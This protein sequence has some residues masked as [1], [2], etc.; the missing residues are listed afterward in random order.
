MLRFENKNSVK[1]LKYKLIT[2]DEDCK[3]IYNEY[4]CKILTNAK[5]K[6]DNNTTWDNCKKLSN[7]YELIHI[8]SKKNNNSIASYIPLSRSYFKMWEIL[9]DFKLISKNKNISIACIAE[10]PGGFIESIINY[11]KKYSS[12]KDDINAITLKSVNNDI[13]GWKKAKEFLNNNK[14][15]KICY[16]KDHTGDIYKVENIIYFQNIVGYN[17]ADFISADGGF[18]FSKNFNKQ[19]QL[20]YKIIFCE[21]ITA[22]SIQKKGGSF[23]CKIFDTYT[24]FTIKLLY[25]INNFYDKLSI[26]KPLTSRPANS[27]KYI[28]AEG[29]KGINK[30]DLKQL[31]KLLKDWNILNNSKYV[32]DIYVD[33]IDEKFI[34]KIITFNNLNSYKQ[35]NSIINTLCISKKEKEEISN[36]I[37]KQSLNALNWCNKY[38]IQI[39]SNSQYLKNL[40]ETFINNNDGYNIQNDNNIKNDN[41]IQNDD[42]NETNNINQ[43]NNINKNLIL[44]NNDYSSNNNY[45]LDCNVSIKNINNDSPSITI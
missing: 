25:L 17:S 23:V 45:I 20:S 30:S 12:L 27:E 38:N 31:F 39:N 1:K 42:I 14:N 13:P 35:L 43:N 36:I 2:S 34:E 5:N 16:G 41:N 4:I 40:S 8:P 7:E 33:D 21:I 19:E 44:D 24:K 29:F 28:I 9:N 26:I 22:L 6:I 32:N 15:I 18:D 3:P 10:G 11:R 37:N